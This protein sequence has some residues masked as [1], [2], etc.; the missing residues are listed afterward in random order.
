MKQQQIQDYYSQTPSA[1]WLALI[2]ICLTNF[3]ISISHSAANV[4][5]PVIASELNAEA[6]LISWIPTAFLLSNVIMLLP[7]GRL[8]DIY[9]RKK[10]FIIGLSI[11]IV[12]SFLAYLAANIEVLIFTRFLQGIGAAMMFATGM[13]IV[14]SLFNEKNRGMALG[15][16]SGSLY[17]GMTCGPL[18]GG[19][20]TE[21][22]GW[23][24]VFLFPVIVSF[25]SLIL[26]LMKLKGEWKTDDATPLDWTGSLIFALWSSSLFVAVSLFPKSGSYVLILFSVFFLYLFFWQQSRSKHPLLRFRAIMDNHIFSRSLIASLCVYASSFPMIF[27]FSLY[28]QFIKGLSPT[29]AGQIIILQAMMMA[30]L[31]PISGRLSDLI[32]PRIIT[33]TGCLIMAMAFA[34]LQQIDSGTSL[35]IFSAC[36]ITLGT[37]LGLFS[38]PNN[39]A[40][41]SSVGKDRLSIASALL[42][43]SRSLGNMFGSAL[44]LLFVALIIGDAQIEPEQYP[45]LLTVI[46]WSLGLSCLYSLFGAYFSYTRGNLR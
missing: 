26:L 41:L 39:N 44:M 3:I 43:L 22:Y 6:I 7:S 25:I 31:A 42:N 30:V 29:E 20:L 2:S 45:A 23:R 4:A 37:G 38:T 17:V 24:S 14:I 1:R 8:A 13:A 15:F 32:E 46:H 10:I 12:T 5:T 34:L 28:L 40:A 19:W 16:A 33:T 36:L 11:F 35:F 18:I 27:L 9:G 21:S